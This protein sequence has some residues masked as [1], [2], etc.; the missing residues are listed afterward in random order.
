MP[1]NDRGVQL[2]S[3]PFEDDDVQHLVAEVQAYY[4]SIY[5]GPDE[6]PIV[7]GEFAAPRG[8]FVL[9]TDDTGPVAM[10]GWRRRD[11]LVRLFGAPVAEVKR[12]Y[13]SPRAR[14]RGVSRLV[15]ADLERTARLAGVA[16]MVLETGIIQ[17]DAI[18]LYESCGYSRTIDFG[19]YADSDLSRCYAKSLLH[20][21]AT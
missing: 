9:A 3:V 18:A 11:D 10:G 16:V 1:H 13:V 15:L 19:H 12:M 14:R 21:G 4:V 8:A 17:G 20:G 7:D 5:G 2:R 6:S